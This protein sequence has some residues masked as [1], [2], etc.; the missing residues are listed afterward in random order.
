[1]ELYWIALTALGNNKTVR[2]MKI[3]RK[4]VWD[5]IVEHLSKSNP[6][7]LG[8]GSLQSAFRWPVY[9][10]SVNRIQN[11]RLVF[12]PLSTDSN[13][14][15]HFPLVYLYSDNWITLWTLLR[16]EMCMKFW[17]RGRFPLGPPHHQ[18]AYLPHLDRCQSLICLQ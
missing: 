8:K 16:G 1:M 15:S 12:A 4:C 9:G 3:L 18:F 6:V 5:W 17:W 11:P 14:I 7:W 2:Q 13:W 10:I